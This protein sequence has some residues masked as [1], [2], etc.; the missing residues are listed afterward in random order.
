MFYKN[1]MWPFK[2]VSQVSL[3]LLLVFRPKD[4]HKWLFKSSPKPTTKSLITK[5][6][7]AFSLSLKKLKLHL[8]NINYGFIQNKDKM[9]QKFNLERLTRRDAIRKFYLAWLK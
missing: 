7:T 1:L 8:K 3:L 5:T 6:H 9:K 4:S 2:N